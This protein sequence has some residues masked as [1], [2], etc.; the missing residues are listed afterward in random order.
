[1]EG[2]NR[3]Q[4]LAAIITPPVKPR[5]TSNTFLFDE[6]KKKTNPEPIAVTTHVNSPANSACKIGF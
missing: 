1:M 4:K 2:A 6:L 5:D 3:D